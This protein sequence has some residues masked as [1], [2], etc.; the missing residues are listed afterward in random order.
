MRADW[1]GMKRHILLALAVNGAVVNA[2][3]ACS[4][5][6]SAP[7]SART[8]P[9][10][11]DIDAERTKLEDA[12]CAAVGAP[13]CAVLDL[14]DKS[15]DGA[16][17]TPPRLPTV[18][19]SRI[20]APDGFGI[21]VAPWLESQRH[22]HDFLP[23]LAVP[24]DLG[25]VDDSAADLIAS[26]HIVDARLVFADDSL[27]IDLPSL[28]IGIAPIAEETTA[29]RSRLGAVDTLRAHAVE[30]DDVDVIGV[31]DAHAGGS[32]EDALLSLREG[33]AKALIDAVVA[34]NKSVV[35]RAPAEVP[36]G[37]LAGPSVDSMLRP[38]G[39]AQVSLAV[40]LDIS[41]TITANVS[42]DGL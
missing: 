29:V 12:V 6:P 11:V 17:S 8:P 3:T 20:D 30:D 2:T 24:I 10:T 32:G 21:E 25:D 22:I 15:D 40:T 28:E 19:P 41:K 16:A 18:L 33:G 27:T 1:R 38:G 4:F 23:Q 13:A 36:L 34:G 7:V 26:A 14:L 42:V 35:V 9:V 39:S 31:L 37:F 5:S